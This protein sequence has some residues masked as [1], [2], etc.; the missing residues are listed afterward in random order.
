MDTRD[1]GDR[2]GP[3]GTGEAGQEV[4]EQQTHPRHQDLLDEE[5]GRQHSRTTVVAHASVAEGEALPQHV[6]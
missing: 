3:E 1:E 6:P 4:R 5:A 2:A